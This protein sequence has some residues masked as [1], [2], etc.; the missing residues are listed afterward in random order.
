MVLSFG[1]SSILSILLWLR[2]R[3]LSSVSTSAGATPSLD[4]QCGDSQPA[5]YLQRTW[6]RIWTI[7]SPYLL[8]VG[9]STA[10]LFA[11][12]SH[13]KMASGEMGRWL[14]HLHF[15]LDGFMGLMGRL[16]CSCLLMI[17]TLVRNAGSAPPLLLPLQHQHFRTL[18]VELLWHGQQKKNSQPAAAAL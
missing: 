14:F 9:C 10:D 18:A 5:T 15:F 16:R 3:P 2:N 1:S 7:S 17:P 11:E 8:Q 4:E 13:L 6:K 12:A